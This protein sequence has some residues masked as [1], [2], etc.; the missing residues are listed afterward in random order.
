MKM[1]AAAKLFVLLSALG[2]SACSASG[3]NQNLD[4]ASFALS[5]GDYTAAVTAA[6]A[7]IADD[8]SN[9]DAYILLSNG[10]SG[11]AG[12]NILQLLV[13]LTTASNNS[14]AFDIA[15]DSLVALISLASTGGP[16]AETDASVTMATLTGS[17]YDGLCDLHHAIVVLGN[18]TSL[19][20]SQPAYIQKNYFYQ[21]GLLQY[22]EALA[23]PTITAQP[24]TSGTITVASITAT[25]RALAQTGFVSGYA[26]LT[27]AATA[28]PTTNTL[29]TTMSQNYW[30]M[31]NAEAALGAPAAGFSLGVLQDQTLCQLQ[32]ATATTTTV[33][34]CAS[35]TY[36][37]TGAACNSTAPATTGTC[38]Q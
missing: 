29:V 31:R 37:G 34:S 21:L 35:F 6:T 7:A 33:A 15:H 38:T 2:L 12:V 18:A 14:V 3:V 30:V 28:I 13:D 20:S 22:I 32:G 1:P 11:R 27:N 9:L 19:V 4:K 24:T 5:N 36:S 26:N 17:A 23:L 16:C 8:A 10:Y 25:Q